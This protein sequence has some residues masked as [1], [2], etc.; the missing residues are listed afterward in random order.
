MWACYDSVAVR[1]PHTS[2]ILIVFHHSSLFHP[3]TI[4]DDGKRVMDKWGH[5][6]VMEMRSTTTG[7]KVEKAHVYVNGFQQFKTL[8]PPGTPYIMP[9]NWY[10]QVSLKRVRWE[11]QRT[12]SSVG[13]SGGNTPA[14]TT[15]TGGASSTSQ[16]S[17]SSTQQ[18]SSRWVPCGHGEER[19]YSGSQGK[20]TNKYRKRNRSGGWDVF[21]RS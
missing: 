16:H 12:G 18:A 9:T 8:P 20:Y 7:G 4:R 10:D 13:S 15:S 5:H 6:A 11:S 2:I 17:A 19:Y 14:S 3:T 1:D 21:T